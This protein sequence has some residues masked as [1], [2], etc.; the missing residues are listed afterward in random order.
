MASLL[1]LGVAAPWAAHEASAR[2]ADAA[3]FSGRAGGET[4][5]ACHQPAHPTAPPAVARLE[6]L[7]EAW[8][9]G[10]TYRLAVAVEGGPPALPAPQPQGGF[11]LAASAGRFGVPDGM[12]GRVRVV[13]GGH[14]A[15]YLPDGTLLRAWEVEWT[16]PGLAAEPASA[17]FWLAVLAANGNHV[18]ATNA[19]DQ[20]ETLDT[21]A[22]LQALVPPSAAAREAWRALPLAPPQ[23]SWVPGP[24]PTL[25][26]R[27]LDG[28]ATSLSFSLNGAQ[29][30]HRD[31]AA[32]W[33]LRLPGIPAGSHTL[34]LRSHGAGRSSPPLVLEV[35]RPGPAQPAARD[36][37]AAH[38]LPAA[39]LMLALAARRIP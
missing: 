31:T 14:E 13:D 22:T 16:A 5:I 8:E 21:E 27:H 20:G 7:P 37:G 35:P 15:T 19:S 24:E 26:G 34:E 6:G 17:R 3:G 4:C 9:P 30:S 25:R 12:Q 10:R 18:V 33:V 1:L 38:A 29:P 11:D 32:E 36:A 23:A 2:F 39:L 28:N